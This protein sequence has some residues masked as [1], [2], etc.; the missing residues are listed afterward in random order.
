MDARARDR[1]PSSWK[2]T[3]WCACRFLTFC[4]IISAMMARGIRDLWKL[5]KANMMEYPGYLPAGRVETVD[6]YKKEQ[7]SSD[8]LQQQGIKIL[9]L[10]KLQGE[11]TQALVDE[12]PR[13]VRCTVCRKAQRGHC[14]VPEDDLPVNVKI[15]YGCLRRPQTLYL[16]LLCGGK[17]AYGKRFTQHMRAHNGTAKR[18]LTTDLNEGEI[19]RCVPPCRKK[20]RITSAHS[21]RRHKTSCKVWNGIQNDSPD[22][23][24]PDSLYYNPSEDDDGDSVSVSL[25]NMTNLM[26]QN[27]AA[28]AAAAIDLSCNETSSDTLTQKRGTP[29]SHTYQRLVLPPKWEDPSF[30]LR[31]KVQC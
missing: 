2:I 7:N 29:L 8:S 13:Y 18:R 4:F 21:I 27:L 9:S 30:I 16:C 1:W 15:A 10:S 28:A 11:F 12:K 31:S 19:W 25:N 3:L 22:L 26:V 5:M 6:L 20:L 24:D 17:F 14:G 23:D